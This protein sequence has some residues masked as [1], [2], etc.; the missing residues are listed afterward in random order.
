MYATKD[1]KGHMKVSVTL[2]FKVN[3]QG[4]VI[5]FVIFEI[6]DF[7]KVRIDTEILSVPY[8]QPEIWKVI[9]VYM[10]GLEFEGQP[11]RSRNLFQFFWDL[12][13][14]K[15]RNRHQDQICIIITSLV[16]NGK[17]EESLTSN[18]KVICQGHVIY[19][20][21][22]GFYDLNYVENDTNFITLSHL[23]Q[24]L[25]RLTNNG[26]NSVFWPP[27][28]TYDVMTYVTWQRQDD[29]TYAKNV[30]P[31]SSNRYAEAIFAIGII[32][33]VTG[34][35]RQGAGGIHPPLGVRGLI[36]YT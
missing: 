17:V 15:C 11:S 14:Q 2:K 22:F 13:P 27:S 3:C 30:S 26:K 1:K 20:N 7:Q 23:H 25:S 5:D 24:K 18:F 28:C 4:Q 19:F 16:M 35:K 34:E 10:Y 21:I 32:K 12:R 8:L 6:L 31:I 36:L 33:K 9:L 29:V